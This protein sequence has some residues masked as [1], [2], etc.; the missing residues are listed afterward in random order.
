MQHFCPICHKPTA[1][2]TH[3]DF[4]FCSERCKLLDLGAWASERYRISEPTF[5]E[6]ELEGVDQ[7]ASPSDAE[8]G[9]R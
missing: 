1:S 4:P 5:D 7:D 2:E 6:S 3:V 8:G 9:D